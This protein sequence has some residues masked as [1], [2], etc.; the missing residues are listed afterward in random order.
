ME[1]TGWIDAWALHTYRVISDGA[2][3]IKIR[4]WGD[5]AKR[6]V[7]QSDMDSILVRR[8]EWGGTLF[9][10]T[11]NQGLVW[12]NYCLYAFVLILNLFADLL[13]CPY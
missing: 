5:V 12:E 11:L 2:S 10:L 7:P 1:A 4:C 8:E 9:S 6:N 13:I 3:R